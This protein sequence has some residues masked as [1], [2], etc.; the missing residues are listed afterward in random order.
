MVMGQALRVAILGVVVG[1]ALA[2][3]LGRLLASLLFQVGA[4][5]PLT[6]GGVAAL[7]TVVAMVGAWLPARAATRVDPMTALR[8]E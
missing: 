6:F 8:S 5:D 1:L 3:A 4:S 2:L 7:M